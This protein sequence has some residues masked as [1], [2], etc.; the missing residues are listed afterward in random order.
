M[1]RPVDQYVGAFP[2]GVD[3]SFGTH[4]SAL[5]CASTKSTAQF[6]D[7]KSLLTRVTLCFTAL[8]TLIFARSDAYASQNVSLI[9]LEQKPAIGLVLQLGTGL[10]A[11]SIS[12]VQD[13]AAR[14][15]KTSY[16]VRFLS[17][18][19]LEDC[20]STQCYADK[21]KTEEG[22]KDLS[23]VFLISV[24]A[25]S[26]KEDEVSIIGLRLKDGKVFAR[27]EGASFSKE[28]VLQTKLEN[29]SKQTIDAVNQLHPRGQ[30]ALQIDRADL[31]V[32]LNGLLIGHSKVGVLNVEG[33]LAGN[34]EIQLMGD[35][36]EPLSKSITLAAGQSR[37]LAL[38][39]KSR[40]QSPLKTILMVSGSSAIV[41]GIGMTT[42][43]MHQSEST[44]DVLCLKPK[45]ADTSACGMGQEFLRFPGANS[46]TD[47]NG[48]SVRIAPLGYSLALAGGTW[49]AGSLI[50][51][52]EEPAQWLIVAAGVVAS[53]VSYGLSVGL[54]GH[55]GFKP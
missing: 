44:S 36:I 20:D 28:E 26:P 48:G 32:H 3:C 14:A 46:G 50:A 55:T 49:L 8:L 7:Q 40:S 35:A 41:A 24:E 21:I 4:D 13:L 25:I 17:V 33:L 15:Y 34:Y 38:Q 5:R 11:T 47:P 19:G 18:S 27:L 53:A 39:T 37:E 22:A 51:P 54:E 29:F 9:T 16:E 23:A 42:W 6:F 45:G 52:D 31:A 12:Q 1:T 2:V 30:I 43:A 10:N